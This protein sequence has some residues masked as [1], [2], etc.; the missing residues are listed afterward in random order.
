M[1]AGD[2][3]REGVMMVSCVRHS[4]V[5]AEPIQPGDR[6]PHPRFTEPT[7]HQRATARTGQPW[8]LSIDAVYE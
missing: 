1:V 6:Q 3:G 4:A 5:P 2:E 7:Q 8:S